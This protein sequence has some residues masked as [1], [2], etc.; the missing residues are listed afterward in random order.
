MR[1]SWRPLTT[2]TFRLQHALHGLWPLPYHL[3]NLAVH[4]LTTVLVA[5][6][7]DHLGS[8]W[9][10]AS[11]APPTRYD[12]GVVSRTYDDLI[13]CSPIRRT[14]TRCVEAE[15]THRPG[16]LLLPLPVPTF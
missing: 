3:F 11:H 14:Q 4:A 6:L 10:P 16:P 1:Q 12:A 8:L 5:L 9:V 7:A 13:T 2:L 15:S